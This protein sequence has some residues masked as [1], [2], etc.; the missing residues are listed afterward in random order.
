MN[1]MRPASISRIAVVLRREHISKAGGA[2][3]SMVA[4][5]A[6]PAVISI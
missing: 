5:T 2:R 3:S 1:L 6:L 4:R